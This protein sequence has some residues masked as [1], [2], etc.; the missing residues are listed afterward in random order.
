MKY[1]LAGRE[2]VRVGRRTFLR[3]GVLCCC[4]SLLAIIMLGGMA[5]AAGKTDAILLSCMDYRIDDESV[6]YMSGRGMG[7]KYDHIIL[8]GASF[9]ALTDKY[10][11]WGKTFWD[12]LDLAIQLHGIDQVILMDHRDCGAYKAILGE[13]FS[14]NPSKETIVHTK[15]LKELRKQIK[16]R[17]P[18]LKVEL[19]L[20]DLDGKVEKIE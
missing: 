9:G 12:H 5:R 17:Y 18:S 10:P 8:A 3:I 16:A 20:M 1:T 2:R 19:L 6:R 11:A 14:K 15:N 13:D 7:N 4:A